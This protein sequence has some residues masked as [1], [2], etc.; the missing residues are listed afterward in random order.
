MASTG[1][2]CYVR[3][4]AVAAATAGHAT[5]AV[6]YFSVRAVSGLWSTAGVAASADTRGALTWLPHSRHPIG[7]VTIGG[8]RY[9]VEVDPFYYRHLHTV[10]E[11]KLGGVDGDTLPDVAATV[12]AAIS[13]AAAAEAQVSALTQKTQTNAEALSA[14]IAV[15]RRNALNGSD[16]IP[17]VEL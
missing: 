16:Q 5:G 3:P 6:S 2:I 14:T 12:T 1:A 4:R 9:P 8:K 11:V 15:A 17:G 7:W 13:T 10:A